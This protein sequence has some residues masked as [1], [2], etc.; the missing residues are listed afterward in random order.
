MCEPA[1]REK[2]GITVS[3]DYAFMGSEERDENSQPSL[4]IFD[5]D[6]EAFWELSLNP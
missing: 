5:A 6:K 3:C 1:D 4:I 2:L